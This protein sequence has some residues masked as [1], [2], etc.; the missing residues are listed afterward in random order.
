MLFGT[1]RQN[2]DRAM[3]AAHI[4]YIPGVLLL[5]IALGFRLGAKAARDELKRQHKERWQ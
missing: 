2:L 1:Y 5:G 3:T 4:L